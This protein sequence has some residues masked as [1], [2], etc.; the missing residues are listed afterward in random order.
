MDKKLPALPSEQKDCLT[1]L[2][3][4]RRITTNTAILLM[5]FLCLLCSQSSYAQFTITE[6][7]KGNSA[8]NVTLGGGAKLTSGSIDP[9]GDGWLRLTEDELNQAGFAYVNQSFPSSLGILMDFEYTAWR[10]S[11]PTFGGADGFS[12]FLFDATTNPFR[13]GASGGSLGYAQSTN[14]QGLA[15]GYVGIGI[16]EFG[17][18]ANS[19]GGKV[20]GAPIGTNTTD[21]ISA[22]GPASSSY[23]YLSGSAAGVSIDYDVLTQTR[24][25]STQFYRR[26]QVEITPSGA[27]YS[28]TVRLKTSETGA[29]RTV[30]GPT[31]LTSAPPANLKLGFAAST[32]GGFNKHEVRNLI[33]TTPGNVRV[34]K[35]VNQPLAKVGDLLTYKVTV[36]NE[37]GS[38]LNGL[39]LTDAFTPANGFNISSV[40]FSNDGFTGNT[41]SGYSNTSFANI[42][43]NMIAKSSMTFTVSGTVM[44]KP[45]NGQLQNKAYVSPSSIGITDPD[46]SNDTSL[47]ITQIINP[48]L[49]LTK[50]KTGNLRP[51]G[52]GSYLLTVTNVGTDAKPN[53]ST[54]SIQ[55]N[56]PTGLTLNG[57]PSG[58]G[59][60]FTPVAGAVVASRTDALAIGAAYPSITVPVSVA[61]N[62][63]NTIVNL[64]IASNE[65]DANSTNN[66]ATDTADTRKVA[67]LELVSITP[68]PATVCVG[69]TIQYTFVV[70][71]NGPEAAS[72]ARIN[73]SVPAGFT[74][75][76]RVSR[77]LATTGTGS[78]G[79]GTTSGTSYVDSVN[80][81]NSASATY[82]FTAVAA[83]R[84]ANGIGIANVSVMRS[85]T[86]IDPD[87]TD[88]MVANPTDPQ[89][90]CDGAPSGAGCNN[91]KSGSVTISAAPTTSDAGPDQSLCVATSATLAGNTPSV[92]TGTWTQLAGGPNTATITNPAQANT[93][94]TGLVPGVYNFRWAI[95]NGSCAASADTVRITVVPQTTTANAGPD[96]VLCNAT[97]ATLAGNTPTNGAGAWS[98]L[99]GPNTAAI[100]NPAQG[101]TPIT[102]LIPGTYRFRWAITNAPCATSA[103]TV[104]ITVQALPTAANAGADQT[105]YNSGIFNI[106]GNTPTTGTGQWSVAAGS[107]ATIANA[108]NATTMAT[109][110]PNTTA[111]LVWTISNGSCP[112]SRDTV[113]LTFTRR[114]DARITK[115]DA[116]N[117]YRTGS[118]LTYTLTVENDGPSDALGL[119]IQDLLPEDMENISWTA[120]GTGA[121]VS[122]SPATGTGR[123]I[124]IDADIP[125]GAGNK[126]VVTIT[127]RIKTTSVGGKTITN[128]GSVATDITIPDPNNNN[129]AST[130]TGTVPNNPPVAVDDNFSTPRDVAVSG[131]VKTN[132][133]DPE[134]DP[135]TVTTTPISGPS[136]GT[137]TLNA[138]GT[139]TYTPN[140]GF[141]GTDKFVYSICDN[142]NAC[143]HA[144]VTIAVLAATADLK[145]R[146]TANP[147]TV[148]AG[149]NLTYTIT[150]INNGPSTIQSS[151][152][153]FVRDDLP[154]NFTA[155]SYTASA[156]TF[157]S[158]NHSW[159]GVTLAPGA[160]VS[161]AIAGS[162]SSAANGTIANSAT[163][164]PPTGV[165]DPTPDTATVTT[166]VSLTGD[167]SVTK[168]D[169]KTTYTPGTGI[170]YTIVVKN[171]GPSDVRGAR[172]TDALPTGITSATWNAAAAGGA[173]LPASSGNG[174]I[175]QL[176]NIPAGD[177]ITYNFTIQVPSSYASVNTDGSL[178]NTASVTAPNGFTDNNTNNNS[179][180]DTDQASTVNNLNITKTGPASAVAGDS[181]I[182]NIVVVNNGPSDMVNAAVADVLPS[183]I[184][185][186]KWTVTTAGT[187]TASVTSGTG[188]VSLTTTIPAGTAN[189]ITINIRGKLNTAAVGAVSNTAT[190]T[191]AGKT[192]VNSN[193]VTTTL[194]TQTGI[195]VVKVGPPNGRVAAGSTINYTVTVT[196]AGPS[197]ATGVNISDIIPA[198]ITEVVWNI[199]ASGSVTPASNAPFSGTGNN[200]STAANIP[201]GAGNTLVINVSGRVRP[202]ATDTLVNT[203]TA[204][205]SGGIAVTGTNKT[206]VI[207]QPGLVITKSGPDTVSAG[208]AIVYTLNVTNNG[209][210]DAVNAT[211]SDVL[212]NLIDAGVSWTATATGTATV[213]SGA[214]GNGYNLQVTGNIPAGSGNAINIRISGIVKPAA[215]GSFDN[216]STVNV[217]GQP[218]ITSNTIITN[219]RYSP[220]LTLSKA[221]D[222]T[223][224]AGAPVIYTLTLSNAGPSDAFNVTI[225]DTI[226]PQVLL[227]DVHTAIQGNA[228]ILSGDINTDAAGNNILTVVANVAAGSGNQA[229]ITVDG[230]AD[231]AFEG[232]IIN[233]AFAK[234]G[235]R[236]VVPSP[237]V[238]TVIVNEADLQVEKDA[239][240]TIAAGTDIT[241]TV[242]VNNE[243][244]SDAKNITIRDQ[245]PVQISNVRWTATTVGRATITGSTSGTGNAVSVQGTI[246][247]GPANEITVTITGRVDAAFTDTLKNVATATIPGKP[248][249]TS[250]TAK[251]KVQN[252][253]NV[254]I[255]KAGP[256]TLAAGSN[257][258][259]TIDVTNAGPSDAKNVAINDQLP[260]GVTMTGWSATATNGAVINSGNSGTANPVA[261]NADIPAAG[262]AKVTITI[263]GKVGAAVE[264]TIKNGATAQPAGQPI[265]TDTVRTLITNQPNLIITKVGADTLAAGDPI[266]YLITVINNG[267][268]DAKNVQLTDMIPAAIQNPAWTTT[269]A[270]GVTITTG[271]TG[272]GSNLV[273]N[274]NIPAASGNKLTI[275]ITGMVAPDFTG[276]LQNTATG[277]PAGKTPVQSDTV[278]TTIV[279]RAALRVT[280][281]A[282][283][284]LA[285]GT[286]ISYTIDIVNAGPSNARNVRIEDLVDANIDNVT[287]DIT[288]ATNATVT[289]GA[290]GTG[291]NVVVVADIMAAAGNKLT[292]RIQGSVKAAFTG[293]INNSA[294]ATPAGQPPVTSNITTTEIV[295]Q[296]AVKVVKTGPAS[297]AAGE[298]VVYTITL[299]NDGPS[300]A[301]NVQ[302][303]DIVPAAVIRTSWSTN[304]N[305]AVITSGATGTGNNVQLV[306]SIP[307]GTGNNVV[308]TIRGTVDS[309]FTGTSLVNTATATPAGKDPVTST[310]TTAVTNKPSLLVTKAGATVARAGDS[311]IYTITI[312]NAGPSVAGNIS[313]ADNLPAGLSGSNWTATAAG[314]GTTVSATS[315]TGT[316]INIT[317][318]LPP[319][320]NDVITLVIRTK[321][322]AAFTGASV[323]NTVTVTPAGQP[324]VQSQIT[325][326]VS[327]EA[328]LVVLKSGPVNA[329]AG[330]SIF[331][332]ITV[333]NNGPSDAAGIQITDNMPAEL[334]GATWSATTTGTGVTITPASGSGNISALATIPANAG[335]VTILVRGRIAPGTNSMTITNTA[336][337]VPPAGVTDPSPA[338]GIVVTNLS[339]DADLVIVKTG[340]ANKAAGEQ[341]SYELRITNRGPSTV[342]GATIQD[343]LPSGITNIS[344]TTATEGTATVTPVVINGQMVSLTATISPDNGDAVRVTIRGIVDPAATGRIVNTA[345]VTLPADVHE[346]DPSTNSSEIGT[347]ITTKVGILISKSGPASVNVGDEIVYTM[348]LSNNGP[349]DANG[350]VVTDAVPAGIDPATWSWTATVQGVAGVSATSGTGN[351]SVTANVGGSSSGK[352]IFTARGR[353]T[354]AASGAIVNTV[355]ASFGGD[356]SSTFVTTVNNSVDLRIS[357]TAP[358]T[359]AAG[360]TIVYVVNVRN[361]GP[362]SLTGGTINDV[363]PANVQGVT[364]TAE[365]GGGATANPASGSNNTININTNIPVNTGFVRITV[366][367]KVNPAFT[368]TLTNT[369]SATPPAGV[370]DPSPAQVSVNTIVT[371]KAGLRVVKSG[372]TAIAAGNVIQYQVAV[373]NDGPSDATNV[374]ITDQVPATIQ[375]VN[376][377]ASAGSNAVL[378]GTATGNTNAVA[379]AANIPVGG[380]VNITVSGTVAP[381]FSGAINNTATASANNISVNSN[382]ITTTVTNTPSL[383]VVKSGPEVLDAGAPVH[384]TIT[385][386][387]NGPSTALDVQIA[388]ILPDSV[389]NASWSATANGTAVING[390][391]L[392]GQQGDVA[393]SATI[394]AGSDNTVI[395]MVDGII[396]PDATTSVINTA[397]ATPAGGTTVTSTPVV[398]R[399]RNTPGLQLVKAAPPVIDAG[400]IL[401]YTIDV[402]N[403]GPSN[404]RGITITDQLPVQLDPATRTWSANTEGAATIAGGN[405]NGQTG[406]VNLTADMPAGSGNSI[407]I[408]I[409][410]RVAPSFS[411]TISNQAT[412]TF[413]DGR[414]VPSNEVSTTVNNTPGLRISKSGPARGIAGG[415]ITY[416][417]NVTNNGPSDAAG[418]TIADIL[419]AQLQNATWSATAAGSAVIQGGNIADRPGNVNLVAN[420][421]AGTGN[422]IAVM[423]T[424]TINPAFTGTFSNTA[425]YTLPG[426]TAVSS[427]PVQTTVTNQPG[428]RVSK[429]GIG[430]LAAGSE[431]RY[432]ITVSNL[433]PSDAPG[434]SITDNIP[435]AIQPVSWT[436]TAQGAAVINGPAN[437]NSSTINVGADLPAGSNNGV[438]INIVGTVSA[439]F[440]GQLKN[441]TSVSK[442]GVVQTRDSVTTTVTNRPG[443]QFTKSGP[444]TIAAGTPIRYTIDAVNIGP[445]DASGVVIQ[446]IVPVTVRNV[447]WTATIQGAAVINGAAN[448]TGNNVFINA[449]LPA[450]SANTVHITVTGDVDPAYQGTL[451]NLATLKHRDSVYTSDISTIVRNQANVTVSKIGPANVAAGAPITYVI[452][453]GNQGP[454]NVSGLQIRDV[455]PAVV[456]QVGWTVTARGNATVTGASSGTGNNIVIAGNVAAG[457]GNEL[458]IT[459]TGTVN[460][461]ATSGV[462]TNTASVDK[463]DGTTVTSAPVTTQIDAT[464]SRISLSKVA[465][466]TANAGE[467]LTYTINVANA[468]PA[469]AKGLT[470]RDTVPAQLRNVTWTATA[471]GNA[472]VQGG[473]TANGSGNII[474]ISA[475][476]AAGNANRIT[477][478][479]T[480]TI[481]PAFSGT[482]NN[483][484][485]AINGTGVTT[486][487][488]TTATRV[489]RQADLYINKTGLDQVINKD[490]MYYRLEIGNRGAGAADGATVTDQL[491]AGIRNARAEVQS[492]T[493]GAANVSLAVNSNVLQGTIGTLPAGGVVRILIRAI[494]DGSGQLENT[495]SVQPPPGVTDPIVTDN[496]S[497]KVVTPILPQTPLQITKEVLTAGPYAVG[498]TVRYRLTVSAPGVLTLN[499]VNVTD[500]L[501]PANKVSDPAISAPAAGSA[502]YDAGTRRI[503]WVI[504]VMRPNATASL[505]Y[506]V[507]LRESGNIVNTAIVKVTGRDNQPNPAIPD[508]AI[509]TLNNE[510]LADLRLVKTLDNNTPMRVGGK[511]DFTLTLTNTGPNTATN[512]VVDDQ[513]VSN[514]DQTGSFDATVGVATYDVIN[515][516]ISWRIPSLAT[517]QNAV[518]KFSARING[519]GTV[520]NEATATAKERDPD[521]SNNKSRTR[522]EQVTGDNIYVPNVITPNGDGKNDK[523]VIVGIERFPGSSL[524]IYNRWG[525]QVFQSKNYRNEWDGNG[526]NEGTYYY[527]LELKMPEGTKV[528]KGWIELLR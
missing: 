357:K 221:A 389:I 486:S 459:V 481:D 527:L 223:V 410:G 49:Q 101:N 96:Q 321:I 115:S 504:G 35:T 322:D 306:A 277:T 332:T 208:A 203:A 60:T 326:T 262:A 81:N 133:S 508:T 91:I 215:S 77:T 178:S 271:A 32:G 407:R 476:L 140:A 97:T 260:A 137:L 400:N 384:Y 188:N 139:F 58:T 82:V 517:G 167:L 511:A 160:S 112:P 380:V 524:L 319:G 132:D 283:D 398:T 118:T 257:I 201:V 169:G 363:V 399:I 456:Q 94:I 408:T 266:T 51:G 154:A 36:Y 441:L 156:G 146:K 151:E 428:L 368:G 276:S 185:G 15:G 220:D 30:F 150:V 311:L 161:L 13:I 315:G 197:D 387:N 68:A 21:F 498:S 419:P 222:D 482:L 246:P 135:L 393:F 472:T 308:V 129:N 451:T 479:I 521:P 235:N 288:T 75:L 116:G 450:G 429:N 110:Q 348:E 147:A 340:P 474:G 514:L 279:N 438:T 369:A 371:A 297:I 163:T 463:P 360:D 124:D 272:T 397:T 195:N 245:V 448:G 102:G 6:N 422:S 289:S 226:P 358:A 330:D 495:A 458:Q 128:T 392:G 158:S 300:D 453:V 237:E 176:V 421:P 216:A 72:N 205:P 192:P 67:D 227:P 411:G 89:R 238:P 210:S 274:A 317:G 312:R 269:V 41:A 241:Y 293:K 374:N 181:I 350:V 295:N 61:A 4:R 84:P 477:L 103:D 17:N 99:N 513:L 489:G 26:V 264:D 402:Y 324:S 143:A 92:G 404:A 520:V 446:D 338:T 444:T 522:E 372:P 105:N 44:N 460:A 29:F 240:D 366:K 134:N 98:Q 516:R 361:V 76:T 427:T 310:I 483:T 299:T 378:T 336:T 484:A 206:A 261:V 379:T 294:T 355:V 468:G 113:I 375:G 303:Q 125:F 2:H 331:Y 406:N 42:T 344:A 395:V 275:N 284:T 157:N 73:F 354:A 415:P 334:T 418:V 401:T 142:K 426:G 437:G 193:T 232:R 109:L 200:I 63:P 11:N 211:I 114:A 107:T 252:K 174:A 149:Q 127:G 356:E 45:A 329:L 24:P 184:I 318:T 175:D 328:D 28:I 255:S 9:N 409:T 43:M 376:W 342:T 62:A 492:A 436:A 339:K 265:V 386:S 39:P 359:I 3:I 506:E 390:G 501:P 413:P 165:T 23:S 79:A 78:F 499:P 452:S 256:S 345:S 198:D 254:R 90:E 16:D 126:I 382:T 233:R 351:I 518:L 213:T 447:N 34:Q 525:N 95:N 305:G 186:A 503:A 217:P 190:V 381:D 327:R 259:Y 388:D 475:D 500:Q 5:A 225:T 291:S 464:A 218:D 153:F 347:D 155:T 145:V 396:H 7:F 405:L 121:G 485:Y 457:A 166:P 224:A 377:N 27:N 391:N 236:P 214:T 343:V 304:A 443:I 70:R 439:G 249:I 309:S 273:L 424:G 493:G 187:A 471:T 496:T 346:T 494:A 267:P 433:G 239:P 22:R 59:W 467:T 52:T 136:N 412:A 152:T 352:V 173:T 423:I 64:A 442:G 33:I 230:V 440:E 280:K 56:L 487:S 462:I 123:V 478:Q 199:T 179:A 373:H 171:A 287:W 117:T 106:T 93:T 435:A 131:N 14:Q 523:F 383:R 104:D 204:T 470:I 54:V 168:T 515:R 278:I 170:E 314:A 189:S 469:N 207:N 38:A 31:T 209:P 48:D 18:Y 466:T 285:A 394:P 53:L 349:S 37:T 250:D 353:V 229:I 40:S 465:A 138:D 202:G 432:V 445:S 141:T 307:A 57:S 416:M 74:N 449:D 417:I 159:T 47:A 480:G 108:N 505:E 488:N 242:S 66:V 502:S 473:A 253:S 316:A 243:G 228:R 196:N 365:T 296:P 219:I 290:T 122:F 248:A 298:N 526:L 367:G 65:Y 512:V 510:E 86:D 180:T 519:P 341:I 83:T 491:P 191:P 12:I 385:I 148:V 162:V 1:L 323:N 286:R 425:T 8:G 231:P 100:T 403:N 292:I 120:T 130:V 270:G 430:T 333:K 455:V 55:D 268:S 119:V 364:W 247:T 362:A 10:R 172:V 25:T 194:N 19:G 320:A 251:T 302:L 282:P 182:Y 87:A 301:P 20:G 258:S 50:A 461:D 111:A 337:A 183:T 313:I 528:Y 434:I 370:V 454:S 88:N 177:S 497:D 234:T 244:L 431:I 46:N 420:V 212:S 80:L 71:N 325:T 85:A 507:T 263:N 281:S 69:G 144:T 490:S 164:T 335:T 509:S 414:V